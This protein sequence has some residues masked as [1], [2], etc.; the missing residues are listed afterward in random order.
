MC[1]NITLTN[2]DETGMVNE[3]DEECECLF[4]DWKKRIEVNKSL[5]VSVVKSGDCSYELEEVVEQ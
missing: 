5:C 4:E 1:I 3:E 2:K